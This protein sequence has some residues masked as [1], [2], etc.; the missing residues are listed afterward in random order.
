MTE[1]RLNRLREPGA[2]EGF[3]V[4]GPRKGCHLLGMI[5]HGGGRVVLLFELW[6]K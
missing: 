2:S 1:P 3:V 5:G 4:S 6:R